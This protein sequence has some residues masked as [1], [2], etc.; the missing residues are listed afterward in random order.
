MERCKYRLIIQRLCML[1]FGTKVVRL[2][3]WYP[4]LAPH[5]SPLNKVSVEKIHPQRVCTGQGLTLRFPH[6]A[7]FSAECAAFTVEVDY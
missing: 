7:V 3:K 1:M 5:L 4:M 6:S 2:Q